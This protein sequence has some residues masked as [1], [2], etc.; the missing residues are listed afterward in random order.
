M[1]RHPVTSSR[2]LTRSSA[3]D[4]F[5]APSRL[6]VA[7]G[8]RPRR[9]PRRR[10]AM[11]ASDPAPFAVSDDDSA[12][13]RVT[14]FTHSLCPYAHRTAL[15]LAE[16]GVPHKRIHVDLS[17]KPRW[18]LDVNPRGLVPALETADGAV[19]TE[20]L[21]LVEFVDEAFEGPNLAPPG[22]E[23]E[24]RRLA[25]SFDGG[26]VSVGL[27]FVGG[28]WGFSRGAPDPP[29][30]V[31]GLR[32]SAKRSATSS[33]PTAALSSSA[34]R[35]PSRTSPCIPSPSDSRRP[36]AS[37]NE[38]N[39]ATWVATG[40][41]GGSTRCEVDHPSKAF[42]RTKTRFS[43]PGDERCVWI[44]STTRPRT[45]IIR[46]R[47]AKGGAPFGRGLVDAGTRRDFER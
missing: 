20:S 47:A 4:M 10:A 25:R 45:C 34:G 33:T 15:A 44:I 43:P 22:R 6:G 16:K 27:Q 31:R 41:V 14:F 23:A 9:V 46:E 2:G 17:N 21:D 7:S 1:T 13:A 24:A 28:G 32:E 39:F 3:N 19:L 42:V 37:L 30:G 38:R 11:A 40:S 12:S 26:F 8:T 36:R 29:R 35:F 5:A 18:Y